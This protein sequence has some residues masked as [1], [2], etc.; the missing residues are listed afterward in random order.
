MTEKY[1]GEGGEKG[2]LRVKSCDSPPKTFPKTSTTNRLY[3]KYHK[4]LTG[5]GTYGE[6]SG[7]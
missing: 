4:W 1:I 7:R 5:E 6:A 3:G 2:N